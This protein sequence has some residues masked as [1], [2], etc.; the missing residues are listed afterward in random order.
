MPKCA[1]QRWLMQ[2]KTT[3]VFVVLDATLTAEVHDA[4]DQSVIPAKAGIQSGESQLVIPAKAGIQPGE[5]DGS[6]PARG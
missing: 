2:I 3:F 6:P 1:K 5:A 4:D